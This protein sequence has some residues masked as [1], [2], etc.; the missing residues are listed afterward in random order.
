MPDQIL[1]GT[2][3]LGLWS[4]RDGGQNF[5][6]NYGAF[7]KESPYEARV[8]GIAIDPKNTKVIYA[9]DE[10][11]V[12]KS[13]D[14]GMKWER[15]RGA[16]DGHSIWALAID[17]E[18]TNVIYAGTRPPFLFRSK[19]A[20]K[21]WEKL[22]CPIPQV[23]SIGVPRVTAIRIDPSNHKH[24][25]AAAEIGG[26]YRSLDGGDTWARVKGGLN[27]TDE[28]ADIHNL[29]LVPNS[30]VETKDGKPH[31]V[32]GTKTTAL[33]T[34]MDYLFATDDNGESVHMLINK[35]QFSLPYL[36]GTAVKTDD[37]K[38][39]VMGTG[40]WALGAA[41]TV[42]KS[43]DGGSTWQ[44][45]KLPG[46]VNSP[47]FHVVAHPGKPNQFVA[48]T[49]KGQLYSSDDAGESWHKVTQEFSEIRALAWQ[50]A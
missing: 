19:D 14:G 37:P 24:V 43:T 22:S 12:L 26:V 33:I 28:H 13:V 38:T 11:G 15:Q 27:E 48:A 7:G 44:E 40:D 16:L 20:G 47:V 6:P 32:P 34:I 1:V 8:R 41:G 36:R 46:H 3:G 49:L 2:V 39:I 30:K 9:G 45:K 35:R 29:T 4:S 25:W 31:V 42:W 17:P 5:M 21:T 10:D 18:D 23:C 50:P